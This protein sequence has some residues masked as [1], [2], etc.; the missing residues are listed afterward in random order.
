MRI[1][2]CMILLLV[3]QAQ[4]DGNGVAKSWPENKEGQV[5]T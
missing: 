5:V 2:A 1:I 3:R 4:A